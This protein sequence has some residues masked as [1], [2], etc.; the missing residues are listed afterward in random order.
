MKIS[1]AIPC[2]NEEENVKRIVPELFPVMER[3]TND[4]E[5][6]LVDD[7]SKDSTVA[8]IEKIKRPQIRLV[9]HGVNKGIAQAIR[10]CIDAVHGDVV[11]FL[12]ADFTFHPN[13]IPSLVDTFK[14]HPEVDF[15]IGS[16][17]LGGY[18]KDV[19]LY[20]IIIS[21]IAGKVFRFLLGK[22]ITA[23]T[24]IFRIYKVPQL[25]ELTLTS[26]GYDI[27]VEILFKLVFRGRK[28][29]EIPAVL[30]TRKHGVSRMNY[31]KEISRASLLICK[32]I[33]WKYF[34]GA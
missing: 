23:A 34:G 5:V 17:H 6:V 9:K 33:K 19:P 15:V 14:Q 29:I 4:F 28:F 22:P 32:V 25:K 27:I 13:L 20:R 16:S 18:D 24:Q 7:G 26:G 10:T 11:I 3:M 30:T 21:N 31:F 12:D 8:E 2:Y 1:I